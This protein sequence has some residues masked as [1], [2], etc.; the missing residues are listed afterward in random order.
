M[1]ARMPIQSM[2]LIQSTWLCSLAR[3]Y[4]YAISLFA[5]LSADA[6]TMPGEPAGV[7]WRW[8]QRQRAQHPG[9]ARTLIGVQRFVDLGQ[10]HHEVRLVV[11]Q[12]SELRV[13][14]ELPWDML[15][16]AQAATTAAT[17]GRPQS[18]SNPS[19]A[20]R[21]T[22]AIKLAMNVARFSLV[23]TIV[24][25]T[26]CVGDPAAFCAGPPIERSTLTSGFFLLA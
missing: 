5:S 26:F 8:D 1:G 2:M 7:R 22:Q 3:S 19:K 24:D 10:Q 13:P 11:R 25:R 17:N 16:L 12:P 20:C 4:P 21:R 14:R 18:M 15:P 6:A 23:D 9:V